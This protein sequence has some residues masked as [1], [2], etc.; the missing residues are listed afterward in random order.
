MNEMRR[1]L[2]RMFQIQ[3]MTSSHSF[4]LENN[5]VRRRQEL[6]ESTRRLQHIQRELDSANAQTK[7]WQRIATTSY[8][9][10]S[11]ARRTK[12]EMERKVHSIADRMLQK[13]RERRRLCRSSSCA[14]EWS[15][16]AKELATAFDAVHR[17]S[18]CARHGHRIR[19]R[20]MGMTAPTSRS[21]TALPS[22]QCDYSF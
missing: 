3:R 13:I 10:A 1:E 14:N 21:Q 16:M 7:S 20:D 6:D 22:H 18:C 11:E 15:E 9:Q 5:L 8:A 4:R 19:T 12:A 2:D 17:S